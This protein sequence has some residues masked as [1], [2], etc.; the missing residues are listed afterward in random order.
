MILVLTSE[1][2]PHVDEVVPYLEALRAPYFRFNPA[3]FPLRSKLIL[4]HGPGG[5]FAYLEVEGEV[6]DLDS[7]RVVWSRRPGSP[8][9]ELETTDERTA[10]FADEECGELLK[11]V[12][13]SLEATWFPAPRWH[14]LRL[15][16]KHWQLGV[17]AELGF[18]IA[19][20]L[21][22]NDPE[23]LFSF[24]REYGHGPGRSIVSKLHGSALVRHFGEDFRRYTEVVGSRDITALRSVAK[25]PMVFQAEVPKDREVRVTVIG[26]EAYAVAIQ[27]QT[28]RRTQTDWRRYD[29]L[30]TPHEEFELPGPVAARCV[31]LCHKLDLRFGAIDLILRPDGEYVFLEVNPNGQYLWLE[32]L[33]GSPLSQAVA[34]ELARLAGYGPEPTQFPSP[35]PATG[36]R[37]R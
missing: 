36:G 15:Q 23:A 29:D 31:A 2:D 16:P 37:P 5:R 33:S 3:D 27:S 17:A 6:L 1:T 26:D 14:I 12:W 32:T 21:I 9:C 34:T 35:D 30:R 10:L 24:Y 7:V 22:S 4:R 8:K 19:D 13:D 28:T 25:G 11:S 20:T 18:T